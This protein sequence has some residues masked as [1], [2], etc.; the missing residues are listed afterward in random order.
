MKQFIILLK[1]KQRGTLSDDLLHAHVKH[2]KELKSKNILV[3]CGPFTD[4]NGAVKIIKARNLEEAEFIANWDP[5]TKNGYYQN[6]EIH[7]FIEANEENNYLLV[8]D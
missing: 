3:I 6:Y 4:N 8:E 1:D 2:L 5:F 7:E